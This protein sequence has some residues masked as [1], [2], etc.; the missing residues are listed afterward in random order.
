[1]TNDVSF[2]YLYLGLGYLYEYDDLI[3]NITNTRIRLG[4]KKNSKLRNLTLSIGSNNSPFDWHLPPRRY[5]GYYLR[6]S[7]FPASIP[8]YLPIIPLDRY[9]VNCCIGLP[10][11]WCTGT[12]LRGP[13]IPRTIVHV[14]KNFLSLFQLQS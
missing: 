14:F 12:Y 4:N 5:I 2:V 9:V 6:Y 1:M 11:S 3:A 8:T 13:P 7:S 10:V